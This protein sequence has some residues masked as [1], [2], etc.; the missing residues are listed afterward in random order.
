MKR[1]ILGQ[2]DVNQRG[3]RVLGLLSYACLKASVSQLVEI[4][5]KISNLLEGFRV[6]QKTFWAWPCLN[7]IAKLLIRKCEA[8]FWVIILK[9]PNLH[10][11]QYT[12]MM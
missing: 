1:H 7:N 4:S 2:S 12:V 10:D 3:N 8:G 6:D 11:P 5:K 9:T